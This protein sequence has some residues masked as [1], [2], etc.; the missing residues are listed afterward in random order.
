ML[1]TPADWLIREFINKINNPER[2]FIR[3]T[4]RALSWPELL[5]KALL[6]RWSSVTNEPVKIWR[7]CPLREEDVSTAAQ[8][9]QI[10]AEEFLSAIAERNVEELAALP[11][12]LLF[13]L[14][15]FRQN[16]LPQQR[17]EIFE[18]GLNLLCEDSPERR[19]SQKKSH[20]STDTRFLAASRMA[21][22]YIL[23]G[24]NGIWHG[25]GVDCPQGLFAVKEIVGT[26][27]CNDIQHTLDEL[28][29]SE[30]LELTGVFARL[31]L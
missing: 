3:I 17:T 8:A 15:L 5:E 12:T 6:E 25:P 20:V 1:P 13:M 26:E 28:A 22:G 19:K 31:D 21:L 9:S 30:T 4:C 11:V 14:K 16:Q 10:N 23:Q 27:N 29:I 18:T 2:V 7:L 24:C